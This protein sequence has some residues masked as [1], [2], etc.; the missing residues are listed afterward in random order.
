[1]ACALLEIDIQVREALVKPAPSVQR[2]RLVAGGCE[3]RMGEPNPFAVE[4]DHASSLGEL[5]VVDGGASQRLQQRHRRCRERRHGDE[6]LP[7]ASGQC[8]QALRYYRS[9]TLGQLDVGVL[10]ADR[11]LDEST[12]QLEREERVPV[13]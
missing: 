7:D 10:G 12:P 3:E 4:L 11:A 1:M 8:S 5:D 9:Q 6:R 13:R 2:H